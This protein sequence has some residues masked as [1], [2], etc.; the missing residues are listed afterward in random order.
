[1]QPSLLQ[2]PVTIHALKD[3]F[4]ALDNVQLEGSFHFIV[5]TRCTTSVSCHKEDFERLEPLPS[6]ITCHGV[7]GDSKVTSGGVIKFDCIDNNGHETFG[8]YNPDIK[9]HLFS[10]QSFFC[11]LPKGTGSFTL[12]WAK[13]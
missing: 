4:S 3:H 9:V 1:M 10:P 6:P 5:D 2:N 7:A 11:G 13:P 8:Y 12:S